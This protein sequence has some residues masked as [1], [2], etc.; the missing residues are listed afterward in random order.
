MMYFDRER[1][2]CLY[3]IPEPLKIAAACPDARQLYNG[4]VV[5][6][7][8]LAN[9]QKLARI[10]LPTIAPMDEFYDWPIKAP[11]K[12]L[13]HQKV[14]SNFMVTNPRC[15]NLS[16]MGTMKTLA[17]LWAAEYVSLHYPPGTCRTLVVCTKSTMRMVWLNEIFNNFIGRRSA[18]V[19]HGDAD[20]R[21][22]LLAEPHDFY[23]INHDG[24]KIGAQRK[25]GQEWTK[26]AQQLRDRQDIKV[27]I[28][29]EASAFND[30]QTDRSKAARQIVV[31]KDYAWL[32]SGTP[33]SNGPLDA[34]G[35]AKLVNG[36]YSESFGAYRQRVM[37]Q[38]SQFKWVPR[39]GAQQAVAELLS[40]S[41]RYAIEDCVDL[42]PCTTVAREAEMSADQTRYYKEL[43]KEATMITSSGT[44]ITA[45]NEAVLRMKLIQ[46]AC[47]AVYDERH[48]AHHIDCADRLAVLKEVIREA[49]KKVIVF[50]PL[51]SVLE[52]LKVKLSKEFT[53]EIIN[54]AVSDSKRADVFRAFQQDDDPRVILA[55]PRTMAH[56]LSL[57][58]ATS[59][60]WYA[61]TDS[62]ENYLQ[63]NKRIHRPGQLHAT[64]IVQISS[65]PVER[66]IYRRLANG[67]ALQGSI[68]RLLEDK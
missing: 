54:G 23:I 38:I 33:T 41:V 67:E 53:C 57:V 55:D 39:V 64:S 52:M 3:D 12:P 7:A 17:S 5:V 16:D 30:A 66:E 6:P 51:T 42:P 21:L 4:Y 59:V 28:V 26:V 18:V 46:V 25:K 19:I 13:P 31:P 29:D 56:G 36:A 43:K 24:L 62:V 68:L 34:Y 32:L 48:A 49:T 44:Q 63:A 22:K 40:P 58:S 60:I 50:A 8:H 1:G 45:A 20:K 14:M 10:G 9:L 61:P 11:Y 35:L 27:T 15:F 47:G 65:S 37:M 2:V